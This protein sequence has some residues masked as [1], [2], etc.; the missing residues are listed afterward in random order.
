MV[1][2][3]DE[4][5]FNAWGR[6]VLSIGKLAAGAGAYYTSMV[7]DGAEEYYTGDREAPGRW[8]GGGSA[9]LG[10]DGSVQSEGF[11]AVLEH[12]HP[13]TGVRMTAARS[14]PTV[15]AFDATFCAPKSV[16]ILHGLGSDDLRA[17]VRDAHD[18]A[19]NAALAVLEDEAARGRRGRGGSLVVDGDGFVG[20]AFRHRTSRAGDPHP[21][22]HVVIANLVQGPDDRWTALDARPMFHWAKPVGYLYEAHLRHELTQRLGAEWLPVRHGIADLQRVPKQVVDEFSTRRREIAAHLEASGFESARAAQLAAYATRRMKDHSSTPESLAAGWQRRAEAHGFDAERVSRALLNHH[23]T[24]AIDLPDLDSLFGQLAAPDGLTWSRSTFGRR[25]VIQAICERL[26]DGAPVDRIIEWSELFLES[27]HCIQ[28][29]GGSSPT[30][31]TRSGTT[32]AARTDET[33]FTT[34][35][36]LATERRLVDGAFARVRDRVGEATLDQVGAALSARPTMSDEQELMV[37]QI[38][39]SGR[40]V[41][42]VEGVAGA[43]KTFA[44]A[45]AREAWQAAGHPVIGCALAAKAARQLQTDAGIPSQTID[46]LLLDLDRPEA[47]GFAPGTVLVVDEAAMVGTRK[48]ARLLD[49]AAHA[50]AKVVLVG[51]PCQLPEIEAGGAFVGLAARLGNVGLVENRRQRDP[52]ERAALARLRA[53]ETDPVIDEYLDRRRVTIAS[54]G[55]DARCRMVEEWLGTRGDQTAVMLASR[56]DDVEQ[57]NEQARARLAESGVIG[58]DE[59]VLGGRGFATGD[60]VLALRNDRRLDV[61]NGTRAVIE[62]ID[63][64]HQ[65]IH[66]RTDDH[67]PLRLPFDYAASR[68]LTHAYAMT[69]HK[70]QGATYDRCFVLVGDQLTKESAYTAL[71]R[72]RSGTDLYLVSDHTRV[73]EA[74]MSEL[75]TGPNE[76]LRSAVRRSGAKQLALESEPTGANAPEA[77]EDLGADVGL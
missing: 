58:G 67:R 57:L 59:V 38:C 12:R 22:T 71:S 4:R 8:V 23:V 21:H 49:H 18:A 65:A 2:S 17:V 3:P 43:G 54:T 52:W 44:L 7:A 47:G 70:A 24:A 5:R 62:R 56:L 40:G 68:H 29:A 34:P 66:C 6:A 45:A 36:M 50:R 30:I 42:V 76:L 72:A 10:L 13:G 28:L 14:A 77:D 51:D 37:W 41:D 61:L 53:G 60:L 25:D 15:A 46:R 63:I 74:H 33:T 31:R 16:S 64:E 20:A 55:A 9:E 32:I 69:I 27:D 1:P 39:T 26:P 73:D 35:D 48:L 11:A 75:Q 19:V